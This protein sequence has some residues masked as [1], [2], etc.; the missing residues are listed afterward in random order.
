MLKRFYEQSMLFYASDMLS[1]KSLTRMS[2]KVDQLVFQ[3]I[4]L[5]TRPAQNQVLTIMMCTTRVLL[6]LQGCHF[7]KS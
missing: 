6:Q 7:R 1:S 4:A 2:L 3:V 5:S